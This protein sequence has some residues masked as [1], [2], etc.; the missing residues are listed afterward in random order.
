MSSLLLRRRPMQGR[1]SA[2]SMLFGATGPFLWVFVWLFIG[3][4]LSPTMAGAASCCGGGASS[5]L[6]LP[7][8]TDYMAD[9]SLGLEYYDGF[10]D[11]KGRQKPDP[12][13]SRLAQYRLTPG[14]AYRL[15]P[16]WQASLVVPYVWNS[17]RYAGSSY[18]TRGLGDTSLGFWYETFDTI[19]CVYQVNSIQ[20][21][22][23]AVYLGAAL[24]IPT[25]ISPYDSV[26]NNFDI[27]GKGFYRAD[28]N[29]MVEKSVY[30]WSLTFNL[31]HGVHFSRPVNRENGQ[32]VNPYRKKL[33]DRSMWSLGLGYTQFLEEADTITY[34][35]TQADLREGKTSLD[36]RVDPNSGF[37][38]R[39][40]TA[41]ISY[42]TSDQSWTVKGS[43]NRSPRRNGWGRSF[44]ITDSYT[45]GASR[46]F[47]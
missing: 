33:G 20:D 37:R 10:W 43:W 16:N 30:P 5:G 17:T 8:F 26:E 29:L 42:T 2:L 15:A 45:I 27:T 24:L 1:G 36:G 39:S 32:Y 34:S 11:E 14:G 28:A 13:G 22:K 19:T 41:G 12:P 6:V 40:Q 47:Y 38:K 35:L 9:L 46:V 4:S 21:L 31:S 44:P 23:P 3:L 25:G 18:S 7:K